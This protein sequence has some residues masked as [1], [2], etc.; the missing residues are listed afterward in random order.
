M[1]KQEDMALTETETAQRVSV[2]VSGLRKWRRA[3]CGPP[4]V[5]LGRLIRYPVRDLQTWLR[6]H[7]PSQTR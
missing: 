5:R 7:I 1:E 4:Y 2:S 6:S 3:G